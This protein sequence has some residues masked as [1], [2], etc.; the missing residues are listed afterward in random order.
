MA[1][2]KLNL[3]HINMDSCLSLQKEIKCDSIIFTLGGLSAINGCTMRDEECLIEFHPPST[4]FPPPVN[5]NRKET[6]DEGQRN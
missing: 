2:V 1:K 4:V 6:D 3:K 5:C